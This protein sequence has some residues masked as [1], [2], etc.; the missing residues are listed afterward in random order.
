LKRVFE[1]LKKLEFVVKMPPKSS[2][3]SKGNRGSEGKNGTFI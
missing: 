2:Y 1:E 3:S